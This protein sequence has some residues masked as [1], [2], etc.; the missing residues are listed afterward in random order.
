M[1]SNG[2]S[3]GMSTSG[4]LERVKDL[5]RLARSRGIDLER[6]FGTNEQLGGLCRREVFENRLRGLSVGLA[7]G[8][9]EDDAVGS[10]LS[11]ESLANVASTF[12]TVIDGEAWVDVARMV[13]EQEEIAS[14]LSSQQKNRVWRPEELAAG[15]HPRT[16]GGPLTEF[17]RLFEG[18]RDGPD[19][20]AAILARLRRHAMVK[21]KDAVDSALVTQSALAGATFAATGRRL[22]DPG[23]VLASMGA[24]F[25]AVR[26]YCWH[27]RGRLQKSKRLFAPK[28][29]KT[30]DEWVEESGRRRESKETSFRR[31]LAGL[32]HEV[33]V[34][35]MV[36]KYKIVNKEG[37][38][39]RAIDMLAERYVDSAAGHSEATRLAAREGG[40]SERAAKRE[41][42]V[43]KRRE[44][45]LSERRNA[46]V[47]R[48]LWAD[49]RKARL[50]GKS[51][52]AWLDETLARH[53][54]RKHALG[55]WAETKRG[56]ARRA[57]NEAKQAAPASVLERELRSLVGMCDSRV[58][59]AVRPSRAGLDLEKRLAVLRG[60]KVIT[61]S[62]FHRHFSDVTF[63]LLAEPKVAAKAAAL[64]DLETR[65]ALGK[66]QPGHQLFG[67]PDDARRAA[68]T[69]VAT[70]RADNDETFRRWKVSKI[71]LA[72][73][74]RRAAN[75]AL[76][77]LVK[78]LSA[79]KRRA[80][81]SLRRWRKAQVLVRRQ[82]SKSTIKQREDFLEQA[83]HKRH[84]AYLD[85]KDACA[86]W[87]RLERQ[88]QILQSPS[89]A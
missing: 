37:D 39:E 41:L 81:L 7:S 22:S 85:A 13:S 15:L 76:E 71:K 84:Q 51:F 62:D 35:D 80:K 8:A 14:L 67:S 65:E 55:D 6:W 10:A 64:T 49:F 75:Q 46:G 72:A 45:L 31:A 23:G 59:R 50:P 82:R 16:K 78:E 44:L 73:D 70:K 42:G 68:E 60:T 48:A 1:V 58:G 33:A 61:R 86:S 12:E 28:R 36:A 18:R 89:S 56:L 83:L 40:I 2:E 52:G 24:T 47:S 34:E 79:A 21:C 20:L 3:N 53:D 54:K 4:S 66:S 43:R 38:T 74:E 5:V 26:R 17:R 32:D 88:R 69:I 77:Q 9:Q 57:A 30:W 87:R 29:A 19:L 25:G 11:D 27:L 63:S